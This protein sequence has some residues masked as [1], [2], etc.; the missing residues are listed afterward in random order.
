ME[1]EVGN[2]VEVDWLSLS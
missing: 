1:T 2:W